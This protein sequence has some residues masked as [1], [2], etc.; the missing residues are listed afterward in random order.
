MIVCQAKDANPTVSYTAPK[1]LDAIPKMCRFSYKEDG[2]QPKT[3]VPE[4]IGPIR[5]SSFIMRKQ[6][7]ESS[8]R[9]LR[10]S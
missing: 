9:V 10:N 5:I 8:L 7:R 4:M 1:V 6:L 3:E 2:I